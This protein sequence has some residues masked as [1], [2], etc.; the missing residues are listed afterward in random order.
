MPGPPSPLRR[1]A[2]STTI[3]LRSNTI[4]RLETVERTAGPYQPGTSQLQE[5]AVAPATPSGHQAGVAAILDA[6]QA[7]E[8]P[9]TSARD[10]LLS[11]VMVDAAVR[12]AR[13]RRTIEIDDVLADA[14]WSPYGRGTA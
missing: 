3:A 11:L 8:T 13:E 5:F 2:K 4:I 6:L 12:S 1:T 9:E 14:G 7:D 10:N